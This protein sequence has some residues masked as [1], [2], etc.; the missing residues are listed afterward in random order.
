MGG[1]QTRRVTGSQFGSKNA[2][3]TCQQR[4]AWTYRLRY[5]EVRRPSRPCCTLQGIS[6]AC[7]FDTMKHAEGWI[8]LRGWAKVMR[9][10]Q[11]P[12]QPARQARVLIL[13]GRGTKERATDLEQRYV[14]DLSTKN[15]SQFHPHLP[16]PAGRIHIQ[17]NGPMHPNSPRGATQREHF[18]AERVS[19]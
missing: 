13:R 12:T 10:G 1:R 11:A 15:F 18:A 3:N 5:K 4:Q 14:K 2:T 17:T 9:C 6:L 7:Q 8:R 16:W 19:R